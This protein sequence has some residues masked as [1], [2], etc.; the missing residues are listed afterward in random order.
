MRIP[1][2]IS[3]KMDEGKDNDLLMER[4]LIR[5]PRDLREL[6]DIEKYEYVTLMTAKGEKISLIVD[7]AYADDAKANPLTAY[8]TSEVYN[9]LI[10]NAKDHDIEQCEAIT[11]GCDPELIIVDRTDRSI[12]E[13]Q[14]VFRKWNPVGSDGTLLELRPLPSVDVDVVVRN[15]FIQMAEA[16][17]V[18][19]EGRKLNGNKFDGQNY[20]I[21]ARSYYA[22]PVSLPTNRTI[23]PQTAGFHVHFGLPK[24]LLEWNK[25]H[26]LRQITTILDY[27][28]GV[29]SILI[30]GEH[31]IAR[32]TQT[33]GAYGKPGDFRPGNIT[34]EYRVPGGALM[35]SPETAIG[36]LSVAGLVMDDV[37]SRIKRA[38]NNYENLN[39][40]GTDG[41]MR[42][43]YPDV[44][45]GLKI[46]E[47]ICS[48]SITPARNEMDRIRGG[49][50]KM[51]GYAK[52][53]ENINR[54]LDLV[55]NPKNISEFVEQ[56][57]RVF[58]EQRQ[59]RAVDILQHASASSAISG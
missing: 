58:Y 43:L 9:L 3:K 57:W 13:A 18:L 5:I 24:P 21:L 10:A 27:Y 59:Q 7:S 17:R 19:S 12:F 35:K 33:S 22:P 32:R 25:V 55:S 11:L 56:N 44:P 38:T 37:I 51:V 30:E 42:K 36:L 8:L 46:I 48:P 15:L 52:R 16:R 1:I 31:D 49:F 53:A 39:L 6:A 45:T 28:V 41:E 4:K 23:G 54:F 14:K 26:V 50:E 2:S 34:M 47:T 20:A 29:P 40:V